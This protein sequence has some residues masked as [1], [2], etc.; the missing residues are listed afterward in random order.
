MR[1]SE[2]D[3]LELMATGEYYALQKKDD[4]NREDI[5]IRR[6]DGLALE[7]YNYPYRVNQMPAYIFDKFVREGLLQDDGTDELGG[8]IFRATETPVTEMVVNSLITSHRDGDQV[9]PGK[10]TISG[11][12][13]LN[14]EGT[15]S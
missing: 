11:L 15:L 8:T 4:L 12:A 1:K 7:M 14:P 13:P 6:E 10:V 2:A 3:F 9:K 5:S